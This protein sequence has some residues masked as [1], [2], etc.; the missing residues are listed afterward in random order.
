MLI[1]CLSSAKSCS[2]PDFNDPNFETYGLGILQL[3]TELI[4]GKDVK[5]CQLIDEETGEKINYLPVLGSANK[6][7]EYGYYASKNHSIVLRYH[8]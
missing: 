1:T 3:T 6:S 8:I 4:A 5:V 2:D 7:K